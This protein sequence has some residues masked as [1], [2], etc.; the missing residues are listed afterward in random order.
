[1]INSLIFELYLY[2][3]VLKRAEHGEAVLENETVA[4]KDENKLT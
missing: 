2:L 3:E 1:M 4:V